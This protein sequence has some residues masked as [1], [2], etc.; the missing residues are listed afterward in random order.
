MTVIIFCCCHD[1]ALSYQPSEVGPFFTAQL[2]P[3]DLP[4]PPPHTSSLSSQSAHTP[5][6][7]LTT[8]ITDPY[9]STG[10]WLSDQ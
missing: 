8:H 5:S 9:H 1:I 7:V 10:A 4:R 6:G 2:A 3:P